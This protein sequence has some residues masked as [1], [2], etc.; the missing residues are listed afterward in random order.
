MGITKSQNRVNDQIKCLIWAAQYH[1]TRCKRCCGFHNFNLVAIRH[2]QLLHLCISFVL[3]DQKTL[4][5]LRLDK[6][7]GSK[8]QHWPRLRNHLY[9]TGFYLITISHSIFMFT[10]NAQNGHSLY[11]MV[12]GRRAL[13][14]IMTHTAQG[15]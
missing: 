11:Q 2:N 10:T 4:E 8:L 9:V 14:L 12:Y 6:D 1:S 13:N 3:M 15:S 7:F 5:N